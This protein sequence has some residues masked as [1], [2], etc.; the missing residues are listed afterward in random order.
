[1]WYIWEGW[2]LQ[3]GCAGMG[4]HCIAFWA[5]SCFTHSAGGLGHLMILRLRLA[6]ISL[7]QKLSFLCFVW[8]VHYYSPLLFPQHVLLI[9]I[10]CRAKSSPGTDF[11][12]LSHTLLCQTHVQGTDRAAVVEVDGPSAALSVL[13]SRVTVTEVLKYSLTWVI[14]PSVTTHACTHATDRRS[15]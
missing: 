3:Y 10:H 11:P 5:L 1:M 12:M 8:L 2:Q 6:S 13:L 14:I 9:P 7:L 4:P 15:S